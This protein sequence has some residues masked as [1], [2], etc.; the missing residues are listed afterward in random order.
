MLYLLSY[1]FN[2]CILMLCVYIYAY[3]YYDESS[4]YY[5][6]NLPKLNTY[7]NNS[8]VT[9]T[10]EHAYSDESIDDPSIYGIFYNEYNYPI[11]FKMCKFYGGIHVNQNA[12]KSIL[13]PYDSQRIYIKAPRTDLVRQVN[14]NCYYD[15]PI[16]SNEYLV[17]DLLFYHNINGH[18]HYGMNNSIYYDVD[19]KIKGNGQ[20][21]YYLYEK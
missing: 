13:L 12:M 15:V 21:R 6:F 17:L 1:M 2:V 20:P 10:I 16:S 9:Y 7:V 14:G 11:M 5:G 19:I 8:N 4:K 18:E 3:L